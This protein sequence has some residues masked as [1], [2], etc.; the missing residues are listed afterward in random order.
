MHQS[1]AQQ[2]V[3]DAVATEVRDGPIE[4]QELGPRRVLFQAALDVPIQAL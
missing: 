2:G 3:H 4:Q 1:G